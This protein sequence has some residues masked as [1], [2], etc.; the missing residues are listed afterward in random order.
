[1]TKRTL[2]PQLV[3]ANEEVQIKSCKKRPPMAT[4]KATGSI[5][6]LI[7]QTPENKITHKKFAGKMY[8]GNEIFTNIGFQKL[9]NKSAQK[10][11]DYITGSSDPLNINNNEE[12]N[13]NSRYIIFISNLFCKEF[14][15]LKNN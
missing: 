6:N 3:N 1:M 8:Q 2:I 14:I 11:P 13:R 12:I 4:S 9:S 5:I 15:L 10:K 7:D